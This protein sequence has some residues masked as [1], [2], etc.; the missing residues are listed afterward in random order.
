MPP[1]KRKRA[2]SSP[3]TLPR[4]PID[5]MTHGGHR[6]TGLARGATLGSGSFGV[7]YEAAVQTSAAEPEALA[8]K[9]VSRRE[10]QTQTQTQLLRAGSVL[11]VRCADAATS[12][13]ALLAGHEGRGATE[14]EEATR[15]WL[16]K[17]TRSTSS[18]PVPIQWLERLGDTS[19]RRPDPPRAAA[20]MAMT[21]GSVGEVERVSI[22]SV[23]RAA[24]ELDTGMQVT[25][26]DH[27]QVCRAFRHEEHLDESI[28]DAARELA[29]LTKLRGVSRF[30]VDS[31][32]GGC[33]DD[34]VLIL[35][36]MM[37]SDLGKRIKA[38][39]R[40][41]PEQDAQIFVAS[42]ILGLET[43]HSLGVVHL[44]LKPENAL[45]SDAGLQLADFGLSAAVDDIDDTE[46]QMVGTSLYVARKH[47][48]SAPAAAPL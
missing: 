12:V 24:G 46:L 27:A 22:L 6:V 7:V 2:A 1:A 41:M 31:S 30:I 36:P 37:E 25:P 29:L 23:V 5:T 8:C 17:V 20:G 15:Y 9:E 28:A 33:S 39:P 47:K 38:A 44:D 34:A 10:T 26:S 45:L 40:G 18:D 11:A 48:S 16:C 42:V 19:R 13:S 35:M 14:A 4:P 43:L 21:L 3:P 32:G